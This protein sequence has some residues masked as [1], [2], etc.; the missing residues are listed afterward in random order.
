MAEE[1]V[2]STPRKS[3]TDTSGP[4][5]KDLEYLKESVSASRNYIKK[6]VSDHLFRVYDMSTTSSEYEWD[7]GAERNIC[8]RYRQRKT[9]EY[10]FNFQVTN[11]RAEVLP[12]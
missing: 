10:V 8:K 5:P 9:I 6:H 4:V 3:S 11:G 2:P 1:P 7:G 12:S